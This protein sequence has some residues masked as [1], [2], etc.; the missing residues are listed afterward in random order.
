MMLILPGLSDCNRI[1]AVVCTVSV[2]LI[3]WI[4]S[5]VG[6]QKGQ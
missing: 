5:I 1:A 4:A 6:K 3:V 2:D